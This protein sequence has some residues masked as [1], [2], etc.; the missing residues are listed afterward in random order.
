MQQY[1]TIVQM[2]QAKGEL[3]KANLAEFKDRILVLQGKPQVYGTQLRINH[4]AG[5]WE[6]FPIDDEAHVDTRRSAIGLDPLIEYAKKRGLEYT[7]KQ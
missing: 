6:F 1:L 7:P 3:T 2:A 4:A 5:K